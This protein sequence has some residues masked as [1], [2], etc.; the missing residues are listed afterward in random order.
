M[1]NNPAAAGNNMSRNDLLLYY[2]RS[3]SYYTGSEA[4]TAAD[5]NADMFWNIGPCSP[6]VKRLFRGTY[7]LHL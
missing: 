4:L 5:I 1:C 6:H 3:S 2:A 7:Q